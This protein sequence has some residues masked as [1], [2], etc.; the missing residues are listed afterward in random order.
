MRV[1]LAGDKD[2]FSA[3]LGN[4]FNERLII[5]KRY[6]V[7]HIAMEHIHGRFGDCFRRV[8]TSD[9]AA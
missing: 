2:R 4:R 8:R 3:R 6:D 5:R 9:A 1:I 7:I